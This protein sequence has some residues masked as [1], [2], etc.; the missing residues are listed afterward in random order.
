[1]QRKGAIAGATIAT[2]FWEAATMS[3]HVAKGFTLIELMVVV[4]IVGIIAAIALPSYTEQ[5][6]KSRRAD[7]LRSIGQLQLDMERWRAECAT[8]ADLLACKDFDGDGTVG[9]T[10]GKYPTVPTSSFYTLA[11]SNQAPTTYTI[12]ASPA[13]TQS[14]DRCGNYVFAVSGGV[15]TKSVSTGASN[16]GL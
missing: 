15:V 2:G 5:V 13:G 12:T 4:A 11:L 7:A 16:C 10:E 14:P 1:V 6:H 9:P 3:R 8:F